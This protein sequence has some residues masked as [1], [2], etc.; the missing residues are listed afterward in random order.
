MG[1]KDL[2]KRKESKAV[3]ILDKEETNSIPAQTI[4]IENNSEIWEETVRGLRGEKE[5]G[6]DCMLFKKLDFKNGDKIQI[7]SVE[8]PKEINER[9][10]QWSQGGK[11]LPKRFFKIISAQKGEFILGV[12]YTSATLISKDLTEEKQYD[13]TFSKLDSS[14]LNLEKNIV[15]NSNIK[16]EISYSYNQLLIMCEDIKVNGQS[17]KLKFSLTHDSF[18]CFDDAE[19]TKTNINR[20]K[21]ETAEIRRQLLGLKEIPTHENNNGVIKLLNE[22]SLNDFFGE[23]IALEEIVITSGNR[24]DTVEF[25][26]KKVKSYQVNDLAQGTKRKSSN[27]YS[28]VS[29]PNYVIETSEKG[30]NIKLPEVSKETWLNGINKNLLD[31]VPTGVDEQKSM[32]E[33]FT[34][35]ERVA[36]KSLKFGNSSK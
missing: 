23:N 14:K 12:C 27:G 6:I 16:L 36:T 10:N 28:L 21:E 7:F 33:L 17:M 29:E 20:I 18:A 1:L 13:F 31:V 26:D 9:V 22:I 25:K 19:I 4:D 5:T 2:F 15:C 8:V 35:I 30:V 24:E 3:S 32:E 11:N 34:K